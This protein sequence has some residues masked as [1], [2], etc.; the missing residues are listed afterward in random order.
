VSLVS[1]NPF[2][3]RSRTRHHDFAEALDHSVAFD[4]SKG[5]ETAP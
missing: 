1:P 4:K 5:E 2:A 3:L